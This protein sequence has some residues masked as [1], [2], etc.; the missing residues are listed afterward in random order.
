[1]IIHISWL[2]EH[3]HICDQEARIETEIPVLSLY[4]TNVLGEFDC[5]RAWKEGL[6]LVLEKWEFQVSSIFHIADKV[7]GSYITRMKKKS[8]MV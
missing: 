1:M 5:V 4:F 2:L 6:V 8:F 3:R 7:E